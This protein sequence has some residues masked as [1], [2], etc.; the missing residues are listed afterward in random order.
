MKPF[1]SFIK[2]KCFLSITASPLLTVT[3]PI[4]MTLLFIPQ[5]LKCLQ[6]SLSFL[7]TS[8]PGNENFTYHCL[9]GTGGHPPQINKTKARIHI[10]LN[11]SL[12]FSEFVCLSFSQLPVLKI[13]KSSWTPFQVSSPGLNIH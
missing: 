7:A 13:S 2:P 6:Y 8:F 9:F 10:P 3:S 5:S 4:L 12:T 11:Q 1:V